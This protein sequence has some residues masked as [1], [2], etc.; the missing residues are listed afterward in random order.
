[1]I[2]ML[3]YKNIFP[4]SQNF[5]S[6]VA[7]LGPGIIELREDN[8]NKEK[9]NKYGTYFVLMPCLMLMQPVIYLMITGQPT[10]DQLQVQQ[11]MQ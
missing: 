7:V 2:H 10:A 1:M 11:P 4:C 5:N 8:L 9:V 3:C 6:P